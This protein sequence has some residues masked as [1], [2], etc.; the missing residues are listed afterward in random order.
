MKKQRME[1]EIIQ[2]EAGEQSKSPQL[3]DQQLDLVLAVRR[4][5]QVR[6]CTNR[7]RR[8]SI[9]K[10]SSLNF[11]HPRR[12]RPTSVKRSHYAYACEHRR[13]A[14]IGDQ[15]QGLRCCLPL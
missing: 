8:A 9:L 11:D 2:Q 5:H 3:T 4:T 12:F 6:S 1:N 14:E 10:K 7:C 13:S 15:D